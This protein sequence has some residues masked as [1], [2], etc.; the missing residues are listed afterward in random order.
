[1]EFSFSNQ[2]ELHSCSA[3]QGYSVEMEMQQ[4]IPLPDCLFASTMFRHRLF[5]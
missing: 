2:L 4:G 1:M 3:Y 5:S